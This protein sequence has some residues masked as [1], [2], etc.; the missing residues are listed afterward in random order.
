MAFD[1]RIS[2]QLAQGFGAMNHNRGDGVRGCERGF[3]DYSMTI[4]SCKE[5]SARFGHISALDPAISS[6]VGSVSGAFVDEYSAG[7]ETYR[8]CRKEVAIEVSNGQ[9]IG[10]AG[11]SPGQLA[12]DFGVYD[13]RVTHTF[14][15]SARFGDENS[16]YLHAVSC[17]PYFG[18]TNQSW[19]TSVAGSSVSG[20]HRTIAPAGGT[21]E[22]DVP[23]TAQGT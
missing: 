4:Y 22:Q 11:G 3:T 15:N 7:G 23:G 19:L 12:L 9:V 21:V 16:S 2:C 13:T 20:P 5:V 8:I 1:L 6:T 17:I 18:G 10:T 14:A